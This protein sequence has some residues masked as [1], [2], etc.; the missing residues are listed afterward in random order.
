MAP[1]SDDYL[2][3]DWIE[4]MPEAEVWLVVACRLGAINHALLSLDKLKHLDRSPARIL[5]NAVT[6]SDDCW[7]EPT[8][9]AIA[10]FLSGASHACVLTHGSEVRPHLW[11]T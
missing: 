5:L 6:P 9:Q 1:L 4:A 3:C 7:L 10:P 11:R 8:R 2:V